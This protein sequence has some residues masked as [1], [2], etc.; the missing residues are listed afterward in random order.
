MA[1]DPTPTLV[2]FAGELADTARRIALPHFRA[3][4]AIEQKGDA[5]PVT[6][7][8]QQAEAEIRSLIET[9]YPDH[10]VFG[11]EHG[12]HGIDRR[13][14]WVI[15]PIDGTR[16]FI[17]GVPLWGTLIA[18]LEDGVPVLGIID[19]PA[20]NERWIGCR[21]QATTWNGR[22]CR[23]RACAGLAE[24]S[25]L[26]TS[27]DMF[28]P[29]EL[30]VFDRISHAARFRR[31]GTDCYGYGLLAA[32]FADAVMESDLKPYDYCALVPVIEGAGG[33][34]TDWQGQALGLHSGGQ[35]VACGDAT[36]H[37]AMVAD[38]NR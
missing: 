15:D 37:A 17:A 5:S 21:G 2:A 28:T 7:A 8:D 9:R 26:S 14:V 3:G 16:S 32:G 35:V 6:L 13:H 25:L 31:F 10:G 24:A 12:A 11:E 34:I 30:A 36:L 20:L 1:A 29:A 33:V 4:L 23:T 38:I 19:M 18:L 22:P 27:P